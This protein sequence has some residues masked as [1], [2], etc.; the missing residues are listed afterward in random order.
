MEKNLEACEKDCLNKALVLSP[1]KINDFDIFELS[2]MIM[3]LEYAIHYT[4]ECIFA[5]SFVGIEE[6][7]D[8]IKSIMDELKN[9]LEIVK[10]ARRSKINGEN[11][12]E[13]FMKDVNA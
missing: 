9:Y 13:N 2:E 6:T 11:K 1:E 5:L 4:K 3:S 12:M 10:S 8:R 7:S